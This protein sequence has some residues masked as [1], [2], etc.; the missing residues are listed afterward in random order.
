MAGKKK[1]SKKVSKKAVKKVVFLYVEEAL[2]K[3]RRAELAK[4]AESHGLKTSKVDPSI[5]EALEK[6]K[7][8]K[9]GKENC[10]LTKNELIEKL[11]T[12]TK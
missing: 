11:L 12:V 3:K 10:G 7:S 9:K 6:A 8:D 2:Q 4:I 5:A 1:V